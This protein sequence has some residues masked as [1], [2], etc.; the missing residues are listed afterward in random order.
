MSAIAIL[1]RG[2]LGAHKP[3]VARALAEA[4]GGCAISIDEVLLAHE[5]AEV[6][7]ESIPLRNLVTANA[8][9]MPAARLALSEGRAVVFDGS[10]THAAQIDHLVSTLVATV[11]L[12]VA[13]IVITLASTL[14]I[15]MIPEGTDAGDP[16]L[17]GAGG[18][19]DDLVD[20]TV[21]Q[22]LAALAPHLPET[23][24]LDVTG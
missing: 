13:P 19:T 23:R 6:E 12:D 1:L 21:A 9:A 5:L 16:L 24:E 2:S 3:R 4:L 20:E 7:A 10:F 18:G 8:L 15:C 17:S 14:E 22:L 11:N